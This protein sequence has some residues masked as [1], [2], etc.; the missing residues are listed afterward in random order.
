MGTRQ[1][2]IVAS[3]SLL[4]ATACGTPRGRLDASPSPSQS[5][6]EISHPTGAEDLILRVELGGGFTIPLAGYSAVPTFSLMGDGTIVTQGPQ[7]EIYPPPALPNLLA[8]SVTEAGIQALLERARTAGLFGPD[9]HYDNPM[10]ADAGTTFFT[11]IAEGKTHRI[12]AYALYEGDNESP[13]EDREE[14]A[15]LSAFQ[16]ELGDLDRI[17]PAGSLGTEA[18]Y[19]AARL[20]VT[21]IS[22]EADKEQATKPWPL[23][24]PV[25]SFGKAVSN[26]EGARCGTVSG[27]DKQKMLS[28]ATQTNTQTR[29]SSQDKLYTL[30][31]RPIL[32]D[33]D[34]C[35]DAYAQAR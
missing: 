26:F 31:L 10:I 21:A 14:R 25:A 34:P 30:M 4:L 22:A 32:P 18:A 28:A 12:S 6:G 13:Q 15:K 3:A 5:P 2:I 29:W 23:G 16:A 9:H 35:R 19:E 24:T 11:L 33:Q 7:I 27:S 8:R 1:I 20:D 17:L